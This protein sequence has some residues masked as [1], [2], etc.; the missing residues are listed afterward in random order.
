MYTK[1][2]S[3]TVNNS[4]IHK[5]SDGNSLADSQQGGWADEPGVSMQWTDTQ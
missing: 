3:M 2:L 5:D 4:F 1:H